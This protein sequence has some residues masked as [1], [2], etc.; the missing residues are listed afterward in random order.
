LTSLMS[1]DL[2]S[3]SSWALPP[4]RNP[5]SL[6]S[7]TLPARFPSSVTF[8]SWPC[9]T[10]SINLEV[11]RVGPGPSYHYILFPWVISSIVMA[12]VTSSTYQR[13]LHLDV[14][15][16]P[17]FWAPEQ[18]MQLSAWYSVRCLRHLKVHMFK[19]EFLILT[20]HQLLLN[21]C[22]LRKRETWNPEII[23][24]TSLSLT[25]PPCI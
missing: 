6:L 25:Q 4:S 11:L 23:S 7:L 1:L 24:D 20:P 18:P 2:S 13:L 16:R 22:S 3:S 10:W 8:R 12:L 21:Y 17:F 9:P 5:P 19:T 14:Q 15:P